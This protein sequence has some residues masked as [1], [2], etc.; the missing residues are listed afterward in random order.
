MLDGYEIGFLVALSGMGL[1]IFLFL[2]AKAVHLLQ[3]R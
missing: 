2:C 3:K 1:G